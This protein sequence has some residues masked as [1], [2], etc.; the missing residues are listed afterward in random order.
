MRIFHHELLSKFS[1]PVGLVFEDI[2]SFPPL[3]KTDL[4]IYELDEELVV[5]QYRSD[6]ITNKGVS[7]NILN[8]SKEGIAIY[9]ENVMMHI[10]GMFIFILY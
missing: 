10:S 1:F 2:L 7:N 8:S 3:Y 4:V 5:Y 6:S 9:R